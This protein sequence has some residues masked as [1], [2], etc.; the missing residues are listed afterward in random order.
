MI[1]DKDDLLDFIAGIEES[2]K[3]WPEWMKN[4]GLMDR[5]RQYKHNWAIEE[6]M[7][8]IRA[9]RTVPWEHVKRRMGIVS[10]CVD[11]MKYQIYKLR[12]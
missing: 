8:D 6:G 1:D 4:I 3:D 12:G 11:R 5:D 7:A 9:G 2:V 10:S